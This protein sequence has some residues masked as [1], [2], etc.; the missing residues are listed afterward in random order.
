VVKIT[1]RAARLGARKDY[2]ADPRNGST[3]TP[4]PVPCARNQ[5][6][7]FRRGPR[8]ARSHLG[9]VE[10]SNRMNGPRALQRI[11]LKRQFGSARGA[12]G[13]E[14][15]TFGFGVGPHVSLSLTK[16][17]QPAVGITAKMR[18]GVRIAQPV[19]GNT[20][21][22]VPPLSQ[23]KGRK[24]RPKASGLMPPAELL[25]VRQV[26]D[27]LRVSTAH[28]YRLAERGELP[29]V[30]VG[31]AMRFVASDL[32]SFMCTLRPRA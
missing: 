7:A 32:P 30:R 27:L 8:A 11:Q 24:G 25:T 14:P 20:R 10:T 5:Q 26:A 22:L 21:S 19:A 29:H 17:S 12:A 2:R 15:A 18:P 9:L 13:V 31:N 1:G 16:A 23:A 6:P 28:V 3:A 4:R